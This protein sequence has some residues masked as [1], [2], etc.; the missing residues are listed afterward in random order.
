MIRFDDLAVFVLAADNG[1]LSAASR[2]LNVA[3]AVASAAVKRLESELDVRL[4]ARSTR[5]L[6]LTPDGERYL[7]YARNALAELRAG[8]DALARGRDEVGGDL[9][10][11]IPSD[12]GRNVLSG[13]LDEFLALYP[14]VSLHVRIGDRIVNL[15]RQPVD[16]VLRYGVPDDSSLIA[17]PL[18][19]DNRRVL[20]ASPA[21]FAR[22]GKPSTPDDLSRHHCLRFALSERTHDQWTFHSGDVARTVKVTGNRVADDGELVRRWA[23]GGYG[24]AYK[25]RLDVL[26]DLRAGRLESALDAWTTEATP[27]NLVYTHRLALSPT[28]DALRDFLR[29]RIAAYLA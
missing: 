21:Y 7:A 3:P 25:S 22:H 23:V 19:P 26:D 17:A 24:I 5:S 11:S 6:R 9:T 2:L 12:F 8:K 13:W 10:L 18:A 29:A 27:L 1:S 4:L 14:A 16:A 20:C 28:L 15:F